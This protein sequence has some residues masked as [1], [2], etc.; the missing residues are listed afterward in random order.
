MGFLSI[1]LFLL[2]FGVL[3]LGWRL[4]GSSENQDKTLIK[5]LALLRREILNLQGQVGFLEKEVQ[6]LKLM[7]EVKKADQKLAKKSSKDGFKPSNESSETRESEMGQIEKVELKDHSEVGFNLLEFKKKEPK[8]AGLKERNLLINPKQ[9]VSSSEDEIPCFISP[10]YQQ[11]LELAARG[12][13]VPEI[14][15]ALTISQDAVQMVL[16]TRPKGVIR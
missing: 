11:V 7:N 15:Q 1:T 16:K 13:R 4:Q 10:K 8:T 5:G 12:R 2:G 6:K 14:A 3:F 9:Q